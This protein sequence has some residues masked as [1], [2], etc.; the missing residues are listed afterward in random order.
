[1]GIIARRMLTQL[2]KDCDGNLEKALDQFVF[3]NPDL[4]KHL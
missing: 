1:M 4:L 3:S 2:V